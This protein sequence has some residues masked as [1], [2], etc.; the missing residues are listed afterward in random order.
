M[1]AIWRVTMIDR[2]NYAA[3]AW[4]SLGSGTA[5]EGGGGPKGRVVLH[6]GV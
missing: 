2:G 3:G 6:V 1:D 5:L 4:Q